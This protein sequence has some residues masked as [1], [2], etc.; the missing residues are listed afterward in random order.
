MFSEYHENFHLFGE[1][2]NNQAR[3]IALVT[4]FV[5]TF[6]AAF[7]AAFCPL[8]GAAFVTLACG[9]LSPAGAQTMPAPNI[10]PP[11]EGS[12]SV[13]SPAPYQSPAPIKVIS[14]EVLRRYVEDLS[15]RH[16]I[17]PPDASVITRAELGKYFVRLMQQLS[18]VPPEQFSATDYEQI[19]ILFNEFEDTIQQLRGRMAMALMRT[20]TPGSAVAADI[21]KKVED[22]GLRLAIMEKT[23]ISGDFTF[24][25]QSDMGKSIRDSMAANMRGRINFN[26][27]VFDA[28]SDS[29]RLG[30]GSVFMRLTAA[31]GRFFPRNKF[32]LSPENGLVDAYANPFNS[33]VNEVQIPN[34]QINNNNSNSIR[35]TISMEQM[36][37]QQDIRF[38]KNWKGSYK[39][40]LQNFSNYFNAT[41]MANNETTQFLN[42]SFVNDISWRLNFIGPSTL[43]T[44]ERP[45][46]RGKG[47][48][49]GSAGIISLASRDY[50][51][52]YGGNY[53]V[54]L[55]H[56]LFGKEGNI[57]AGFWNFNFRAGSSQPYITPPELSPSG[58]LSILPGGSPTQSNPTGL[59]ANFDQR[60]WKNIGL[61][62]RY[63]M[64]DKQLG[65]VFLGGLLSSRQSWSLGLEI[66]VGSF[67]KKRPDD[68]IGIAY[69]Q[70]APYN[71]G[72]YTPATPAF[73]GLDG[74]RS[75]TLDQVN[76]ALAATSPG[77]RSANEKIVEM[78]YRYQLN[79][80]VSISPDV[81][82]YWNPGGTA[83]SPG[84][85]V[86]GSRLNVT[87]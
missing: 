53:E 80:N 18:T 85:F 40:G 37:Y 16:G 58:L 76:A 46:F 31:S 64:N 35:P 49:R 3:H 6:V 69:G 66:P 17:A 1:A 9:C 30:E 73:V 29:S 81:Q 21:T 34:L 39:L 20:E 38:T 36:Y 41:T 59:Y 4:P 77:N 24:A 67:S 10:Q 43:L 26:M 8:L 2:L 51:G 22:H 75:T 7:C 25:P 14:T 57:R 63:A 56:H 70:I 55:G 62:G 27:R 28:P 71:R 5:G 23:K 60:I 79:K 33:G 42:T 15:A 54:Q 65:E 48:L 50:F 87:F 72:V 61:W 32:L 78:Y 13:P 12:P 47:F 86:L 84:I 83:P 74:V 44:A 11:T 45:L 82:Y 68:V 19:G 52:G